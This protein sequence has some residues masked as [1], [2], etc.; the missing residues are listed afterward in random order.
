ME[1]LNECAREVLRQQELES[2]FRLCV[3][4]P[5]QSVCDAAL[6]HSQYDRVR[7]QIEEA[8]TFLKDIYVDAAGDTHR[9]YLFQELVLV[10]AERF[11]PTLTLQGSRL[12]VAIPR[13]WLLGGFKPI[14]ARELRRRW[15]S[16]GHLTRHAPERKYWHFLNPVGEFR[17]GVRHA[18]VKVRDRFGDRLAELEERVVGEK[19]WALQGLGEGSESAEAIRRRVASLDDV[20][21]ERLYERVTAKVRDPKSLGD[22]EE[23]GMAKL[24]QSHAVRDYDVRIYAGLVGYGNVHDVHFDIASSRWSRFVRAFEGPR[25]TRVTVTGLIFAGYTIDNISVS[26]DFTGSLEAAVITDALD[27]IGG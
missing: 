2:G 15:D 22:L 18:L 27:E 24:A 10:G 16:G 25:Q 21:I 13:G 6:K 8:G 19:R 4:M 5:E 23:A 17:V 3:R 7:T 26:L 20:L 14:T 1:R 12:V 9:P 11:E